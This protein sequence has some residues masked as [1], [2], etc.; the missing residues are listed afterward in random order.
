MTAPVGKQHGLCQ[1]LGV[2]LDCQISR[3]HVLTE[4]CGGPEV[5]CAPNDVEIPQV[6][7]FFLSGRESGHVKS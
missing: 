6:D 5:V 3:M 7:V 4:R 2:L 1:H